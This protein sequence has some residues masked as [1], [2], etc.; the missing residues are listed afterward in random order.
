[1][2]ANLPMKED[3]LRPKLW[4]SYYLPSIELVH[5]VYQSYLLP[6]H[7]HEELELNLKQGDG[8]HFN[9]RGTIH[10]VPSDT[11]VVTQPGEA[12]QANSESERDCTFRG[13]RVGIDLLQ[14]VAIDVAGR[15]I[16][17]PLFPL[18]LVHDRDFNTKFIR[19]HQ[20]L[21]RSTSQLE[22]QTLTLDLLA[23]LILRYSEKP[24]DLAKLE[25]EIQP[26]HHVRDYLEDN[27]NR[28]ISLEQLAQVANLSSF[29]LNRSFSRT[30]GMPPHAYQIQMRI[31]MAKRLLIKGR[32]IESVA[33]ETGFVSQS[34]FGSHFKRLVCITPKQYIQDSKNAI[35]FGA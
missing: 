20:A 18:P 27:Y 6:R 35:G 21:E 26:V 16:D 8:W 11:L 33:I 19:V 5:G 24:P 32:S 3:L 10:S 28:E 4:R 17:L 9:Y 12:H 15:D 25:T 30:F 2:K 13:L 23:Q 14:Q 7:F 31:I 34:H 22:Q 29:H 1:M